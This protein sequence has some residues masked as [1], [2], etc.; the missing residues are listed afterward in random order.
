M[1]L[2]M[3]R[4]CRVLLLGAALATSAPAPAQTVEE[5]LRDQLRQTT[6]QLRQ[7]LDDNADL[8]GK[9]DAQAQQAAAQQAQAEAAKPSAQQQ[10][11]LAALQRDLAASTQQAATLQQQLDAARQALAQWQKGYQ[12]A[13]EA[14]RTRGADAKKFEAQFQDADTRL[15]ACSADNASLVDISNELLQRYK[16]KGLWGAIADAEPVTGLHR[17]ELEK[18]AQ[19]YHGRI[20][21]ATVAPPGGA[22]APASAAH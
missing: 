7:A 5:R 4:A 8:K 1:K 9:L 10:Q 22:P 3:H 21:D 19:A 12:D 20:V 11:Q 15:K 13:A 17:V 16:S 2:F 6:L 14:A 18:A